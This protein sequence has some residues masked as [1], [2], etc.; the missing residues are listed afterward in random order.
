[1]SIYTQNH[2]IDGWPICKNG[3][4]MGRKECLAELQR[5]ELEIDRKT[6]MCAA[7]AAELEE[8]QV[9]T[10]IKH[11]E[12]IS[13][14]VNTIAEAYTSGFIDR[15]YM[16]IQELHRIAQIHFKDNYGVETPDFS[17]IFGEDAFNECRAISQQW[18]AEIERRETDDT[19][20]AMAAQ[21]RA[22]AYDD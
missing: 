8:I 1:M 12:A 5:L 16:T 11:V 15:P 6:A 18:D 2:N 21:S 20:E 14:L 4:P 10:K 3:E 13:T 19:L 22:D 7:L 17:A 9:A